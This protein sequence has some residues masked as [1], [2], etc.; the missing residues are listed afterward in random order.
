M[1]EE[2]ITESRNFWGGGFRVSRNTGN[3]TFFN[4]LQYKVF[5][6]S[7]NFFYSTCQ[8]L[9]DYFKAGFSFHFFHGW[10]KK[11]CLGMWILFWQVRKINGLETENNKTNPQLLQPWNTPCSITATSRQRVPS[12][13]TSKQFKRKLLRLSQFYL[14]QSVFLLSFPWWK[15]IRAVKRQS[16]NNNRDSRF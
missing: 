15:P 16:S 1:A 11:I 7:P 9:L 6:Y 14:R 2:R 3:F 5:A 8:I 13:A 10:M 4:T 12:T